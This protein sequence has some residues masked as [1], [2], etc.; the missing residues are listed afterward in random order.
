MP[1]SFEFSGVRNTA[2][3]DD[4]SRMDVRASRSF[5]HASWKWTLSGEVLNVLNHKNYYNVNSNI[6][7]FRSTGLYFVS[8]EKSFGVLPSAGVYFEF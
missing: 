1:G 6:I 3:L 2:R 8:I 5:P 7:R 4:Y